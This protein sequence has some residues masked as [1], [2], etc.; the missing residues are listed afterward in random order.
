MVMEEQ[1][2][3]TSPSSSLR[4]HWTTSKFSGVEHRLLISQEVNTV[5]VQSKIILLTIFTLL[6]KLGRVNGWEMHLQNA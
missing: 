5:S 4:N 1:K 2:A 6:G 3:F